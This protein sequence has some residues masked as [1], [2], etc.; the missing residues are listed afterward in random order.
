MV[1]EALRLCGLAGQVR[2][3][4]IIYLAVTSRVLNVKVL[5]NVAVKGPS[6]GG[7][8]YLV[9]VVLEFFPLSAFYALTAIE[10]GA[11]LFRGIF[12]SPVS[13]HL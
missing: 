10:K 6:S 12:I 9:E 8:S 2:E 11:G 5:V 4:K 13:H 1:A 3:A 7:K